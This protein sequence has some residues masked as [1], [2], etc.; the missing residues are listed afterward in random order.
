MLQ[1]AG[2]HPAG[3][4]RTRTGHHRQAQTQRIA[5]RRV[6]AIGRYIEEEI[7]Q[8]LTRE[9]PARSRLRACRPRFG[10]PAHGKKGAGEVQPNLGKIGANG[11]RALERRDRVCRPMGL[12][13]RIA[14]I[15]PAAGIVGIKR[16]RT[17]VQRQGIF[18]AAGIAADES[19]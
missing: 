3:E 8:P 16:E 9:M 5:R 18:Q 11:K 13:Q 19:Q 2:R 12:D 14:E 17:A 1:K 10:G 7:G 4:G 15:V 6:S